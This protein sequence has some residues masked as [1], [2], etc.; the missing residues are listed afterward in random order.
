MAKYNQKTLNGIYKRIVGSMSGLADIDVEIN[1][2]ISPHWDPVHRTIRMPLTISYASNEDEDFM[3]GRSI[4]IHESSHVLFCPEYDPKDKD[5]AEWFNVFAD[6]N[7][8]YKVTELWPHLKKPLGDKTKILV[9]KNPDILK[10]DNPFIQVLMRC[11]KLADLKPEFPTNYSPVLTN[12]VELISKEFHEQD[13]HLAT[14]QQLT[15][16]TDWV[17][18]QWHTLKNIK[19]EEGADG[20][21]EICKLMKE[22][23]ELIKNGASDEEI[24]DKKKEIEDAKGDKQSWFKEDVDKRMVRPADA[25]GSASNYNGYT[26]EELKEMLKKIKEK[27]GV[28]GSEG[29]W[30]NAQI[31]DSKVVQTRPSSFDLD[32]KERLDL[33]P[34]KHDAYKT[35]K[36]VNQAL[37][38]KVQLQTD[39]EKRHRSGRLDFEEIRR[40]VGQMGRVYKENVFERE[41]DFS[42]GGQWA[43][44][45][46][47][48]CSGSMNGVKMARAKQALTTLGYALDGI[49]NIKYALTG[50]NFC[51]S[52]QD[53]QVKKFSDRK[54]DI[55]SLE[56]L[57]AEGGNCDGHNIRSA[58][59]RLTRF[60]N[61][62]KVLVVI[63]DGQPAYNNGIEDTKRA[64]K[65]AEHYGVKVIGIGIPGCT[66]KSLEEIY[67][68]RY[69]FEQTKELHKDLTN[70]ILAALGQ[71]EKIKLVKRKWE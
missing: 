2:Q 66:L 18:A 30:G 52:I 48:D 8:E 57:Q 28:Q 24:A 19:E 9:K 46:L 59:K 25:A 10:S 12:F 14:G 71:K 45:V 15:A 3:L 41:N 35:G 11:D 39:F 50:F 58:T 54:F 32:N 4:C 13:I 17:N 42:R 55:R 27:S 38:R 43:I 34:D 22:L 69:M 56:M 44:E 61:V 51:D 63:S 31:D 16:F 70:L 36:Q 37:K 67:P 7:N 29:G 26:L 33:I 5:N 62:K 40:Q 60:K 47:C 49:P 1:P 21:G 6:C 64:V 20:N 53:I 65:L 68:T 23:G